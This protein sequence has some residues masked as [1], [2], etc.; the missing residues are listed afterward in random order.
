[1]NKSINK[2][3]ERKMSA[4]SEIHLGFFEKYLAL[5]VILCMVI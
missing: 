1:V 3:K 5:W 4:S 2:K